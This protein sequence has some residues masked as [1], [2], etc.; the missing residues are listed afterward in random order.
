MIASTVL[1]NSHPSSGFN[2]QF[3]SLGILLLTVKLLNNLLNTET[4]SAYKL[5][6]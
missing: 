2:F 1:T 4:K 5:N 6:L 3:L